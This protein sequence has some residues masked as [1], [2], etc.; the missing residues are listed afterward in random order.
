M[1]YYNRGDSVETKSGLKGKIVNVNFKDS[2]VDSMTI[3]AD[4]DDTYY[5]GERV[6]VLASNLKPHGQ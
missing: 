2:K 5:K 4:G 6:F 3:E 1:T